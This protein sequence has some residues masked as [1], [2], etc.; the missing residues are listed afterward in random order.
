MLT[1]T[2]DAQ[3]AAARA[4]RPRGRRGPSS[5]QVQ[6]RVDRRRHAAHHTLTHLAVRGPGAR[7]LCTLCGMV[8]QLV[9]RGCRGRAIG[10]AGSGSGSSSGSGSAAGRH[11][12][13]LVNFS[14]GSGDGT[15]FGSLGI[16]S[17]LG[18]A[19]AAVGIECPTNIQVSA[20]ACLLDKP[21]LLSERGRIVVSSLQIC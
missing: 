20:E 2:R 12:S 19:L 1:L 16:D 7:G 5:M 21:N 8:W 9:R 15:S 6:V 17:R 10:A 3:R 18:A 13:R 14:T 11:I 4:R